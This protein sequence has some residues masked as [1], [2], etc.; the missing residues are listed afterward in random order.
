[1]KTALYLGAA[2]GIILVIALFFSRANR[3]ANRILALFVLLLSFNCLFEAIE[4]A[5]FYKR[6]PILIRI[7]WGNTLLFG[8]LIFLYVRA[9]INKRFQIVPH[10]YTFFHC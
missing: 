9:L 1:M 2:Q 10:F 8:P 3:K 5:S 7:R 6:F 4:S